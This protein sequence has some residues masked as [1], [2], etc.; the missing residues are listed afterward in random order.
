MV[1]NIYFS[2]LSILVSAKHYY[3]SLFCFQ[4][5]AL[6]IYILIYVDDILIT[7]NNE[8]FLHQLIT[9]LHNRFQLQNLGNIHCFLGIQVEHTQTGL[10]LHQS[11]YVVE[12]LKKADM[13]DSKSVSTPTPIKFPPSSNSINDLLKQQNYQKIVGSLQYLTITRLDIA[14]SVNKLYQYMHSPQRHH[15]QLLK[16]FFI[17]IKC[18]LT[19]RLS[20]QPRS[21]TLHDY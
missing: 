2:Y 18:T 8:K 20:V 11:K 7:G 3:P 6:S 14:Y 5:L 17:Y 19:F 16:H 21:L 12:L 9:D 13:A 10:F 1:F 15:L 4:R